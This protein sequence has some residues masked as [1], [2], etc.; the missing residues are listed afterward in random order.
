[1]IKLISLHIPRTAG[2]TFYK[3]LSQ[4]YGEE[5]SISIRRKDAEVISNIK[6]GTHSKLSPNIKVIHG[7]LYYEEVKKIHL[8]DK[9][10]IISWLREPVSRV[11]SNYR[12]FMDGL[13]NPAKNPSVYE[14]NKHRINE[15]LLEF[16]QIEEN[17]NRMSKFLSG[18]KLEDL[19]FVGMLETFEKDLNRLS[20]RLNWPEIEVPHLNNVPYENNKDYKVDK[21]LVRKLEDLNALDMEMYNHV[22]RMK[23]QL[24]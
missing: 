23:E 3:I 14:L 22:L 12:F 6:N 24:N 1:M 17:Q 20:K 5:L 21:N 13:H 19:F 2:T 9:L 7:H 18:I 11:I 8:K 10:K 15:T 16:A 4:V